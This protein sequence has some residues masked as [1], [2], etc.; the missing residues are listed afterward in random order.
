MTYRFIRFITK[1]DKIEEDV[2]R[3]LND[4]NTE[5]SNIFFDLKN[6]IIKTS[7][8]EKIHDTMKS[9]ILNLDISDN[10]T[11]DIIVMD[12]SKLIKK[13]GKKRNRQNLN[14]STSIINPKN[15]IIEVSDDSMDPNNLDF[16][17]DVAKHQNNNSIVD[18]K[19]NTIDNIGATCLEILEASEEAGYYLL[20]LKNENLIY[21]KL[22]SYTYE[23]WFNE[24]FY[25]EKIKYLTYIDM[26]SSI[27]N[28]HFKKYNK[29]KSDRHCAFHY[30]NLITYNN[31]IYGHFIIRQNIINFL[32]N[33]KTD[34]EFRNQNNWILNSYEIDS[35]Q[36]HIKRLTCYD[37]VACPENW[38][39]KLDFSIYGYLF[40][41]RFLII[42]D[43]DYKGFNI[44][45]RH[46]N[47]MASNINK[48]LLVIIYYNGSHYEVITEFEYDKNMNESYCFESELDFND[49]C[50]ERNDKLRGIFKLK[51]KSKNKHSIIEDVEEV[52]NDNGNIYGNNYNLRLRSK[53]TYF[54]SNESD[55]SD[56]I[57]TDIN[58][59]PTIYK[60]NKIRQTILPTTNNNDQIKYGKYVNYT[61]DDSMLSKKIRK[62]KKTHQRRKNLI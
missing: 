29:I 23:N 51:E 18:S 14:T 21:H 11:T 57:E 42:I 46:Y 52:N 5:T 50:I 28:F 27:D 3:F 26:N 44:C 49:L 32:N 60:L 10:T 8:K 24:E 30:M 33:V 2:N 31:E 13:R 7:E 43:T 37:S 20:K 48:W 35:F 39:E 6:E 4:E 47:F 19:N 61:N 62:Q 56:I 36:D 40:K 58:Y 17:N 12:D 53:K 9:P 25:K 45:W 38:G 1:K 54:L 41:I 55:D 34:D 16:C 15:R 59:D 22:A